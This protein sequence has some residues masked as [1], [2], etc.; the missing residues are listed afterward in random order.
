MD[1]VLRFSFV[2]PYEEEKVFDITHHG[3]AGISDSTIDH[4]RENVQGN[5]KTVQRPTERKNKRERRELEK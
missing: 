2:G 1:F 4:K 5:K 3:S